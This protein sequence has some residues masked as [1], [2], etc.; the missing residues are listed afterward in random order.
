MPKGGIFHNGSTLCNLRLNI[1]DSK[2]KKSMPDVV[3]ADFS[4]R[5]VIS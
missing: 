4:E 5:K 3:E 1:L 2:K